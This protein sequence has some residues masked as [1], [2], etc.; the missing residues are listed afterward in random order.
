MSD[1]IRLRLP[2]DQRYAPR[3]QIILWNSDSA[4]AILHGRSNECQRQVPVTDHVERAEK[5]VWTDPGQASPSLTC[6]DPF[7]R[8]AGMTVIRDQKGV[9]LPLGYGIEMTL[10]NDDPV[11][12]Q[13][14]ICIA[15]R[16]PDHGHHI[17]NQGDGNPVGTQPVH[18]L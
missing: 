18:R 4:S 5:Q 15:R 9:A 8:S 12:N 7:Q 14:H 16:V 3:Q 10:C 2:I 11:S 17:A 1:Q 6:I 13:N